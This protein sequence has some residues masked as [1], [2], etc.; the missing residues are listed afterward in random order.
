M[1]IKA[2]GQMMGGTTPSQDFINQTQKDQETGNKLFNE[3]KNKQITCQKL[4]NDEFEKIGEYFMGQMVGDT[5]KHAVMNQM[6]QSMMGTTGEES[7]HIQLGKQQ[8]GC[9]GNINMMGGG[10]M[11]M[12]GMPGMVFG[13][14]WGILGIVWSLVWFVFLI[15][16]IVFLVRWLRKTSTQTKNKA[17]LDIAKERYAKGEITKKEFEQIKKDIR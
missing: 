5:A 17:P 15:V 2:N 12:Y 7:M 6:M 1:P 9:G 16:G 4:S 8:S 14:G 10:G 3:L 11:M 13:L